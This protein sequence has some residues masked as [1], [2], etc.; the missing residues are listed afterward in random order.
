M[1]YLYGPVFSRRL[2]RSLG[3]DFFPHKICNF[4]CIYCQLGSYK[5]KYIRRGNFVDLKELEKELYLEKEKIE[6]LDYVSL[7][8]SGEPTLQKNL[9]VIIDL[10]RK[11]FIDIPISLITNSSLL[12]RKD[13]QREIKDIDL[14]IPS[15]DA[16]CISTFKKINRPVSSKLEKILEGLRTFSKNFKGKIWLEI[17]VVRGVNDNLKEMRKIKDLIKDIRYDKLHFNLPVRLPENIKNKFLPDLK[18]LRAI[19]KEIFNNEGEIFGDIDLEIVTKDK[20]S[21]EEEHYLLEEVYNYL[22]RRPAKLEEI[23]LGLRIEKVKL[24]DLLAWGINQGKIIKIAD[25]KYKFKEE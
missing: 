6:E 12:Y 15:L 13:V 1:K 14:L 16:G 20:K 22:K 21:K 2:G 7:S 10:I 24:K 9:D 11:L 19:N 25:N 17:M 18:I 8:G 5:K 23:G 3:I 4:N